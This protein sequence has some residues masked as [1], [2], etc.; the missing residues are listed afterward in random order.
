MKKL[1]LLAAILMTGCGPVTETVK[2]IKGDKGD[3]GQD[4][5]SC[6]LSSVENGVQLSCSDETSFIVYNGIN[7]LD[8]ISGQDG[9]DGE[10]GITGQSGQ[11]GTNGTDGLSCTVEQ[12][13]NG[14][15]INCNNSTATVLNGTDGQNG[16]DGVDGAGGQDGQNG[17]NAVATITNYSSSSCT[18]IVG[19]TV[20]TKPS[21]SGNRGLYT[22]NTCSSNSK[23]AEV[24][25]GEA[26]WVSTSSLA[27]LDG[28]T[29]KV[30]KFN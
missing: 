18:L 19:T 10:N 2:I 14:A 8:G 1:L 3:A 12:L 5:V 22:S 25:Q 21:G 30:I 13:E 27:T 23:Y 7:G 24:S 11:D 15:I 4:G 6:T 26:Y 28:N 16:D 17:S 9:L 20:Y 29:L